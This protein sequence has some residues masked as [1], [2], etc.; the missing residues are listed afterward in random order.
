MSGVI[1]ATNLQTSNIK[2]ATGNAS[3][4]VASDGTFTT[5]S[6]TLTNIKNTSTYNSDGGAVNQ[7]LVQAIVKVWRKFQN[8]ASSYDSF[9]ISSGTDNSTGNYTH[10]FSSNMSA[11]HYSNTLGN[12]TSGNYIITVNQTATSSLTTKSMSDSTAAHDDDG[13]LTLHGDLA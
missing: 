6:P 7:N 8:D 1:T 2:S 3:I 10:T 4:T 11:L 13:A 12:N 5:T 9:N